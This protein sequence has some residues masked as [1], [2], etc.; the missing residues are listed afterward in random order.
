MSEQIVQ[1]KKK[2]FES[3]QEVR[4]CPGCGDYSILATVQRVLADLGAARENNVFISGIGCAA[5][6]PY[7]MSTYGFHTI[8]GRA[9]SFA[10][11]LKMANP[12]LNVWIVSGDG[13]SLSI[14]GNHFMHLMRRNVNVNYLLFNNRIYGLTKGQYSPTSEAGKRTKSTPYGSLEEPVNPVSL[15]LA[16]KASFVARALA[17]DAKGLGAVLREA[18]EH[19]GT[20][21]IE[22]FQNCNVFNNGAFDGFAD[23][24]VREEKQLQLVHG[25]EL[26]FG[27]GGEKVIVL[28]GLTVHVKNRSELADG[29]KPL[30]F[31]RHNVHM[32]SLLGSLGFPE[33]PVPM[34]VIYQEN[35]P[36]YEALVSDQIAQVVKSKGAGNL[37]SMLQ[38]ADSW[39]VK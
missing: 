9:P 37:Q 28:D 27:A 33:Y 31:D 38:G 21:C 29:E 10:T 14:G 4:W 32:A 17:I 25:E 11:G 22:I 2:D 34:G 12:D 30:V 7:Y 13:D 16:S 18:G 39:T 6:F 8:H 23:R 19:Q 36:S 24:E 5:R 15:A 26:A 1:L 3:D 20:S 35:R